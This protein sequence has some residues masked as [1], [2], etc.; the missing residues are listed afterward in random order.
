MFTFLNPLIKI[1]FSLSRMIQNFQNIFNALT[2]ID[3][4]LLATFAVLL[5]SRLLYLFLFTGRVLFRKKVDS[6]NAK[7]KPLS[8]IV[9][10]RNEEENL[11]NNLPK[12]LSLEDIDFEIVAVDDYSQDNSY[13][14]L[15]LLKERYN[16]LKI[17]VLNQETR[18]SMK[19]AQNIAL[20]AAANDWVLSFPVTISEVS[21]TWLSIFSKC[22]N[23]NKTVVVAYSN[24]EQSKG[25]FNRL[26][27]IENYLQYQKSIG[28][29]FNSIPFVYSEDNVAFQKKKYF[30]M[31]GFAQKITE[32]YVNLELIINAFI[33]KSSTT[34][35]LEKESIVRRSV[36]V[37]RE[38]YIDLLKKCVRIENHLSFF[39]RVVLAFDELTKLLFIPVAIV[40]IVSHLVFWPIFVGLLGFQFIS[41]LF[42]IKITQNRLNE[43][44]IFI[45]CLLYDLIMPYLK[46]FYKW[47]FNRQS[48]KRDGR[49]K[50]KIIG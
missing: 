38:D 35:L 15:G 34:I 6:G 33:R 17:S 30:E 16:R 26:Y 27:R 14:I 49:A 3:L 44:K 9:T 48:K 19:L 41:Y 25:F 32:Q 42:I 28:Y 45:S 2:F 1:D 46:L 21:N 47:H 31:G 12:I 39:K 37:K 13:L 23:D 50:Y 22:I 20:K 18:Y 10:V 36:S 4:V 24:I 11:K 29:I 5:L 40:A 8:L 7:A 43:R